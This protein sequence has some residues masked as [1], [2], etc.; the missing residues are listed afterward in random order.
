LQSG[1]VGRDIHEK[2][3][4][5]NNSVF[6]IQPECYLITTNPK[7]ENPTSILRLDAPMI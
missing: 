2:P 1:R 4:V 6:Q 3:V 5:S 7:Q